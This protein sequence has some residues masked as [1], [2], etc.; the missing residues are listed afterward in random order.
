MIL[1]AVGNTRTLL[2]RTHNGVDFDGTS[3]A[4]SLS[5][6]KILQQPGLTWLSAPNREPVAL[7]GVVPAVLAA[8]REALA[9]AEVR[10]PDP[11]FFRRAVPHRYHPPESLGFDRRCCLLAAATDFPGQDSIVIDM[12]TAITIDLLA[13]GHFRGGRILPGIAMSLR[14]LHEGTALLPEVAL[15]IPAEMLGNDTSSAIQAGVIH[16]FADALRGAITDYRQ[17]S[18]QAQILITG[19]DAESWQSGIVG[20]LHRPHLLLR[21]FYLW[22]RG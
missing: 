7:G 9:T 21:G 13:G 10:E 17:Y 5:P 14:G 2:A 11:G 12:G 1:I 19:G 6:A 4:T 16:L 15:N 22:I 20:S 18:P 3:V 8:W